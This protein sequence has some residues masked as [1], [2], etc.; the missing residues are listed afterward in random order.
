[1]KHSFTLFALLTA[2]LL[3]SPS[4]AQQFAAT[5]GIWSVPGSRFSPTD[6]Y[7]PNAGLMWTTMDLTG[8]GYLDLV[9]TSTNPSPNVNEVYGS[10]TA[11]PHWI[12][13]RGSAAGFAP[14]VP[15]TG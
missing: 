3:S 7:Y 15:S 13:Y 2:G 10:G 1:M 8:D 12:V 11:S 5:P 14:A 6:Q 9:S 4:Y